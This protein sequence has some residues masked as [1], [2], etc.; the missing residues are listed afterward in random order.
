M[1]DLEYAE[2]RIEIGFEK[3][4]LPEY[5]MGGVKLWVLEAVPPG[6]FLTAL[7]KNDFL[8]ACGQADDNNSRLLWEWAGFLYNE[9]PAAC[10]G[11]V[12]AVLNWQ[13]LRRMYAGVEDT[14]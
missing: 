3:Y 11:S 5:M 8:G 6:G 12:E 13:G 14:P 9:V 4:H 2:Q 10:K 1:T 7:L